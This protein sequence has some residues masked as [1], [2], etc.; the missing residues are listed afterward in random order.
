M[1]E[2]ETVDTDDELRPARP[3][4]TAETVDTDDELSLHT[5]AV[6]GAAVW[7]LVGPYEFA[8][9]K[10]VQQHLY[11]VHFDDG[12]SRWATAGELVLPDQQVPAR[13]LKPGADILRPQVDDRTVG[14][15][16]AATARTPRTPPIASDRN[17]RGQRFEPA[18]FYA[19]AAMHRAPTSP[20]STHLSHL[21]RVD[22]RPPA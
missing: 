22:V 4:G 10:A 9:V 21:R 8:K 14:F 19:A 1:E 11:H 13:W 16:Q 17:V 20:P 3:G 5:A 18:T 15:S 12:P 7:C 6:D 2:A